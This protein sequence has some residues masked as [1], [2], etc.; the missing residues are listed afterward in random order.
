MVP[1]LD[2]A[3]A[4]FQRNEGLLPSSRRPQLAPIVTRMNSIRIVTFCFLNT[5]SNIIIS[6]IP[7]SYNIL[8]S[9]RLIF[10]RKYRQDGC[11]TNEEV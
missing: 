7:G 9:V 3:F 11:C 4:A 10:C 8:E 1:N 2:K 6:F 5:I